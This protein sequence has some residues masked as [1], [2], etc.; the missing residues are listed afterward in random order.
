MTTAD[1]SI[2]S[3]EITHTKRQNQTIL[4]GEEFL[5]YS[6]QP[7]GAHNAT[8][9]QVTLRAYMKT[10]KDLI[11]TVQ[12][13]RPI[14]IMTVMTMANDYHQHTTVIEITTQFLAMIVDDHHHTITPTPKRA[15]R[16][17][18]ATATK[19]FTDKEHPLDQTTKRTQ[20][21]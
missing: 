8:D 5:M 2:I 17:A 11:T 12:Q 7:C 14:E 1:Q 9:G 10:I 16:V 21:T 20:A 6:Y 3:Y 19:I 4:F 18:Q 13:T 15:V